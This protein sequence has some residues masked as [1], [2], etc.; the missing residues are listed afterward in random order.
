MTSPHTPIS[1]PQA[2]T[3]VPPD[4]V[5][6]DLSLNKLTANGVNEG[7][8][9][10]MYASNTT[11]PETITPPPLA[12]QKRQTRR[13]LTVFLVLSQLGLCAAIGWLGYKQIELQKQLTEQKQTL[14][15]QANQAPW[16][17]W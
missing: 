14:Q 6:S 17:W 9:S 12:V 15:T 7:L 2:G 11:E 8:E 3:T 10:G 13:W 1:T 5:S 16:P 4:S